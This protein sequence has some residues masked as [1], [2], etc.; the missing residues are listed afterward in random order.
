LT[1]ASATYQSLYGTIACAWQVRQEAGEST[2]TVTVTIP[3]NTTAT[4][5]IPASLGR[6][7]TERGTPLEHTEGVTGIRLEPEVTYIE[8]ASGTYT[9]TAV[10]V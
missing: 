7:I 10:P 6:Q 9:F 5:F 2:F 4:V 3:T 1:E 8:V